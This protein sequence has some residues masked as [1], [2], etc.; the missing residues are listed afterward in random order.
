MFASEVMCN[1]NQA[2]YGIEDLVV[3]V[4]KL[5]YVFNMVWVPY[6]LQVQFGH[7]GACANAERETAA[8][9]NNALRSCG[10]HVPKSFDELGTII[11]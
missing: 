10:A 2:D 7:A 6:V 9:K 3:T 5:L 8:A 11:G 1:S 4:C